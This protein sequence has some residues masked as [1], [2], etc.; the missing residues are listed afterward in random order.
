MFKSKLIKFITGLLQN[1]ISGSQGSP[2][3]TCSVQRCGGLFKGLRPLNPF[4][5]IIFAASLMAL[6]L[7]LPLHAGT[8][9]GRVLR[10]SVNPGKGTVGQQFS[11]TLSIAG[12]DLSGIS[13]DLPEKGE[14][15]PQTSSDEKKRGD[16]KS[17]SAEDEKTVPLYIINSAVKNESEA[18][19]MKQ[20]TVTVDI[21]CF[22]PG[23]HPLP[24]ISITDSD[25]VKLGYGIPSVTI[26]ELNSEG[27]PEDIEPPLELSGNYTR[28]III[29]IAALAAAAAG[30]FIYRYFKNRKKRLAVPE[31]KETPLEYFMNEIERLKLRECI[32][33]GR[34]NDYVFGMSISFR[35]FLSMEFGFDAAEMTTGEISSVIRKFPGLRGVHSGDIVRIMEAWDLSKFAEFT[36][37]KEILEVNLRNTISAAEKLTELR[38]GANGQP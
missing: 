20:V 8:D 29:I 7:A 27:E 6:T 16:K 34:V 31:V 19:G 28:L 2:A 11:Y 38:R 32:T 14:L 35:R 24:E 26:E 13:I 18:E 15:F 36:L 10:S 37:S 5:K 30:Y 22:I 1:Y 12:R 25:G 21:T 33:E 17:E 23:V 9:T 3:S 4:K